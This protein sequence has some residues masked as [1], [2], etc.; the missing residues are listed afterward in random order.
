MSCLQVCISI[1]EASPLVH[2]YSKPSENEQ[3]VYEFSLVWDAQI[4]TCFSICEPIF[5][6]WASSSHKLIVVL[7]ASS[8][9][10]IFVLRVFALR[11]VLEERIKLV[12]QGITVFCS[13]AEFLRTGAKL[14]M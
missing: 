4:N 11:A 5:T 12:H 1:L 8:R 14:I 9:K 3:S 13:M 10:L 2:L 6:F 7:G